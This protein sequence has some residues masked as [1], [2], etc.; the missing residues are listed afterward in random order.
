[1]LVRPAVIPDELPAVR[2][3]FEE[4]AADIGVDLCF[5]GFD[6]ELANLPGA[7]A[8][9]GGRLLLVEDGPELVGCVAL[10]SHAPGVW[11]MKRLYVRPAF[12]GRG[13]GAARMLIE[14]LLTEA[15]GAGYQRMV[16]D[17]LPSM[18][19]AIR[20]YRDF[21]FAETT[22]YS[23]NCIAGTLFFGKDLK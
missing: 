20:L 21:G 4:Y 8:P 18:T 16:L 12:R 5:Q 3:L 22:P 10:R 6:Q 14:R 9:P 7:Y 1:M 2:R 17:T 11:E 15:T 19:A 23:C 13:R